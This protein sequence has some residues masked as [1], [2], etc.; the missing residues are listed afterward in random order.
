MNSK[1]RLNTIVSPLAQAGLFKVCLLIKCIHWEIFTHAIWL[2]KIDTQTRHL[3]T[4]SREE[5]CTLFSVCFDYM[6]VCVPTVCLMSL[7]ARRGC[8]TPWYRSYV[9]GCEPPMWVLRIGPGSSARASILKQWA[10]SP[11]PGINFKASLW[12][13]YNLP[14]SRDGCASAQQW[15]GRACLFLHNE[16]N[17]GWV[18]SSAGYRASSTFPRVWWMLRFH[19]HQFKSATV[20][21]YII[22]NGKSALRVTA[23]TVGNPVSIPS[24][25]A[26]NDFF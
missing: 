14:F 1:G 13:V 16:L 10:F 20:H 17:L 7:E 26:F 18:F 4:L 6:Y 23:E 15:G 3:L 11:A 12:W 8:L 24:Q 9:G 19:N 2:Y 21:K 22:Q 5:L 25:K